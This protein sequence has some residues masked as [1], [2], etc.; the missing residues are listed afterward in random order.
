MKKILMITTGILLI[1]ISQEVSAQYEK[2]GWIF[3]GGFNFVDDSGT[4]GSQPLNF[5]DNWNSVFFPSRFS[6]GYA[7]QNGIFFQGFASY[8]QYNTDTTIDGSL[9]TVKSNYY[10]LD[11]M[12][13][14]GF[15]NLIDPRGW[16]DPFL[17][18][19]MGVNR[20]EG[21]NHLTFNMGGGFNFWFNNRFAINLSTLGKWGLGNQSNDNHI[22][23][24]IG[25]IFK[26]DLNGFLSR[27]NK[28]EETLQNNV[29][30]Q[31]SDE[32]NSSLLASTE[33]VSTPDDSPEN[34]KSIT[35]SDSGSE[36]IEAG[37]IAEIFKHL[38][39]DLQS[40]EKISFEVNSSF[41]KPE[42]LKKADQL[43]AF[44][45]YYPTTVIEIRGNTDARGTE[46]YNAWLSVRRAIRI[47]NYLVEKGIDP[48]RLKAVGSIDNK[49]KNP[50]SDEAPCSEEELRESRKVDYILL[51]Y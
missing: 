16:F 42:D 29:V 8:N 28:E 6:L 23:H 12:I 7:L 39:K 37:E 26:P 43:L 34:Q 21:S 33:N 35:N 47:T 17:N 31:Q 38:R 3:G 9:Q 25:V 4:S 41:M 48:K 51:E 14:Y 5:S 2:K 19:G 22:Q 1:L 49:I 24:G 40:I 10:A 30:E 32:V 20:T 18:T 44:M 36:N 45:N 50:C 15:K 46:E 27:E 13:A 11:G